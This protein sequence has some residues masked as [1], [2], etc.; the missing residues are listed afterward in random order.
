MEASE[1]QKAAEL[2]GIDYDELIAFSNKCTAAKADKYFNVETNAQCVDNEYA[3]PDHA[4][5]IVGWDDD[6][7]VENFLP[8]HQPPAPGAWIVRNSWGSA[9]GDEGYF[10]LSYYDRTI[11]AVESF[12][13]QTGEN[14]AGGV[15]IYAYDLMQASAVSSIHMD[16]PVYLSNAFGLN[17]DAVLSQVSVMTADINTQVTVGVYL[18]N[19]DASSVTDGVLLDT[20]TENFEY[21]GYHRMSLS[22]AYVIPAGSYVSVVQLQRVNTTD[23]VR[24][25]IPFSMGLSAEGAA[26]VNTMIYNTPEG[27]LTWKQGNIGENESWVCVGG[28]WTDWKDIINEVQASNQTAALGAYDNL[29]IKLYLYTAE[30]LQSAHSFGTEVAYPGGNAQVC[31]DC[32][33]TVVNL[34]Q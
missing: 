21:A 1:S 4:V 19:E 15:Q 6:Y 16:E 14:L 18:L 9:Y 32:G 8:D 13:Y 12:E 26:V 23:G 22:K 29:S 5:T 3:L 2:L 17:A 25:A 7:A 34:D 28:E 27:S 33:Y 10:Y 11:N 30:G 24:Y 20:V 31:Q